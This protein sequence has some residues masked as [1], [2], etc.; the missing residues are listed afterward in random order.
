MTI[1][2]KQSAQILCPLPYVLQKRN[3]CRLSPFPVSSVH[4]HG[5]GDLLDEVLK[6]LPEENEEDDD[7]DSHDITQ[8]YHNSVPHLISK[9]GP[10]RAVKTHYTLAPSRLSN[11]SP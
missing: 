3:R 1:D 11:A 7:D 5:T 9:S 4:G 2:K 6:Y 8:Q 10:R